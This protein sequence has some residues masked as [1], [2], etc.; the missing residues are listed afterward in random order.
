MA[1]RT[2][3]RAGLRIQVPNM[4][5][6]EIVAYNLTKDAKAIIAL[7]IYLEPPQ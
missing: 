7:L 5:R 3:I 4:E 2:K 6:K 1:G